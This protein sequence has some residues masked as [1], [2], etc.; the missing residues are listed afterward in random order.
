MFWPD[1]DATSHTTQIYFFFKIE[2]PL[3]LLTNTQ[4]P[5]LKTVCWSSA[6]DFHIPTTPGQLRDTSTIF[7]SSTFNNSLSCVY[8]WECIWIVNFMNS[9]WIS[10]T[11]FK[12][13]LFLTLLVIFFPS[14]LLCL[15]HFKGNTVHFPQLPK[16]SPFQSID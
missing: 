8:L 10:V 2:L 4:Y 12:G 16:K 9:V 7:N 11:R 5:F 14:R 15:S 3:Y 6:S 1:M 13:V